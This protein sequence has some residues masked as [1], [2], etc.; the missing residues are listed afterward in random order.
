M[1]LAELDEIK[2]NYKV[3]ELAVDFINPSY[4]ISRAKHLDNSRYIACTL[5]E[6][7]IP[8]A[9]KKDEAAR[10]RL[11]K[12]D[13]TYV[14]NDCDILEDG[15]VLIT[16]TE[17]ILAAEGNAICDIQLVNEQT[18]AVYSTK[19]FIINIDK[20]AVNNSII[21]SSDEFDALN[22]LIATNKKINE[23]LK[24]NEKVRQENENERIE[25]ENRRIENENERKDK[26]NARQ[27]AESE[28]V[29]A[30]NIRKANETV[31]QNQE[32]DRQTN[33]ATA[34]S[35]A[36]K[37]TKKANDAADDL[38]HK[39][40][41]R[42]FVLTEDKDI[43]G[44]VPGLDTNR[45]VPV[46]ELYEATVSSKGITQLIDSVTSTS[47][48]AAATPNSV[49]TAYDAADTE[50][51]RAVSAE[52][53]LETKK[54][55]LADP[56]FT[57]TP[58]APTAAA[59]TNTTQIATTAFVQTAVSNGI[60]ASDAMIIKGTI[61]TT[62]TVK[63]LPAAYKTGWTYRVVTNGTYAG[64][65]CEVGDLI[66]ALTDRNGSG[67]TDSDWCV[68]QTNING[69]ITGIKSG[70]AYIT[71]SQSGSVVTITHKDVAR[72]NTASTAS[73]GYNGTF[74][75]IDSLTSDSKGHVTK[76]NTK[77]VTLP[78]AY[79][80]PSHTSYL[81]RL[82]KIAVDNSGHIISAAAVKKSD[83]T[84]LGIPGS[85]THYTTHLITGASSSAT[86]NAAATN[87]NVWLNILDNTTVRNSHNIVGS[88]SVTVTSDANGKITISGTNTTYN[89]SN[90]SASGL[91]KLYG[92][93]GSAT[94]GTMTQKAL[95]DEF[96][97]YLPLTGGALTGALKLNAGSIVHYSAAG[98]G[99]TG[100]I[101]I[102]KFKISSQYQNSPLVLELS[103][104]GRW[105]TCRLYLYFQ[106]VN[107][108]DPATV[109]FH[110][111]GADYE[112]YVHRSAASTW[113]L[114]VKKSE[115]Y[116]RI[117]VLRYHKPTYMN[118]EV[119][120]LDEYAGSV[121]GGA[122]RA[123]ISGNVMQA[124]KLATA[125][126]INGVAFD[127]TKNITIPAAPTAGSLNYVKVANSKSL[128]SIFLKLIE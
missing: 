61:G 11:Q 73:P 99:S 80:H 69:A 124:H 83:I 108:A 115:A 93:T 70:D 118:V 79:V 50:K 112:S 72:T 105:T 23:E 81:S 24:A 39:L 52:N 67:N 38:Q 125:R 96:G 75:A 56:V 97:K 114:Y 17:Q 100:Y 57:G 49:K 89:T 32:S 127:G 26:E 8:R 126:T 84:A 102:A 10:I 28:R 6:N 111:E 87:G 42:H 2:K 27:N 9:V 16:L 60:A 1:T 44:G 68:A 71:A 5:T 85:D 106:S 58:K 119:T 55:N 123:E 35:N 110:F 82:Y 20:T 54:A 101:K 95:T 63:S 94:D 62:G 14:Y 34:I 45:K 22:K 92:G 121:P 66:V 98:A 4:N 46:A 41:T 12:P 122:M 74:T 18:E 29:K 13:K 86:A 30:E 116:D 104:R 43:A 33:T 53:R 128:F 36:E 21:A 48:T 15:R 107:S 65:V 76:V 40:D 88:G 109:T 77:T 103:S 59:G 51:N 117:E 37:A 113:D 90:T 91:T 31:R 7:G 120:W 78:A 3:L 47:V 25:N 19:N 64:Q